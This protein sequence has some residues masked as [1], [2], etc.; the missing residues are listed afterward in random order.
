MVNR[1]ANVRLFDVRMMGLS[2]FTGV[3]LLQGKAPVLVDTGTTSSA[4]ALIDW[5]RVV[6]APRYVV[7]THAHHDHIGGLNSVLRAFG[8]DSIDVIVSETCARR[9]CDPSEANRIYATEYLAPTSNVRTVREGEELDLGD[10]CLRFHETPGHSADS[11][12][13]HELVS[14][15]LFPGDL[16]GDSLWGTTILPPNAAEDFD[17]R[18]YRASMDRMSNVGARCIALAHYG[19]FVGEEGREL[20]RRQLDGYETW[21]RELLGAYEGR[22]ELSDVAVRVRGLLSGSRFASLD[23]FEQVATAFAHWCML[24]YRSAG[25]VTGS[26][27]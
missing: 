11:L 26:G 24:G 13:M 14:D 20:L 19:M 17:E 5:L 7:I 25:L 22:R 23:D 3:Y 16:P 27:G 9:L 10:M 21:K 6:G 18:A 12:S 8:T 2:E 15:T 4:E 1:H